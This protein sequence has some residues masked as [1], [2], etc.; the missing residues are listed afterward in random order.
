MLLRKLLL[1]LIFATLFTSCGWDLTAPDDGNG[2]SDPDK[3]TRFTN[4]TSDN[5]PNGLD[6]QSTHAQAAYINGDD[7]LDIVVSVVNEP[8]KILI[9]D[10]DGVF[11]DQ[12]TRIPDEQNLNSQN[13]TIADFNSDDNTDLYFSNTQ[14]QSNELYMNNS[15]G[16]FS[17]LSNRIPITGSFTSAVSFDVDENGTM[18][19]VI[20][21]R[22][23]NVILMNS[24]NAFFNNQSAERLPQ[25]SD[26]TLDLAYGDISGDGNDDL[27]I[28][29][30]GDNF[31]LIN[32][33]NGV[34]NNDSNNRLPYLSD[35][36]ESRS[37]A[38]ADVDDD[39]DLDIY[40]GNSDSLQGS[41]PQDRLL[42]NDGDG[43]FSDE[44]SDRLPEIETNTYD[45]EFSDLNND[46]YPDLTVGNHDGGIQI[47]INDGD[48]NFEDKTEEWIPADFEPEV[49]DLEIADFNG[50]DLLDIYVSVQDDQDQ[51]LLQND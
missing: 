21:S 27:V 23:Q 1:Y 20:G 16:D 22:D 7:S 28:A 30:R 17:N 34:F 4:V 48:G 43:Y 6:D 29:N 49:N 13:V 39:N 11:S 37:V 41:N 46:G 25:L 35:I 24:G 15:T 26:A 2:D 38:L 3:E 31:V 36:E 50:D 14:N 40:F 44:T 42:V 10:G 47:L 32:T 45:A 5:L 19:L 12:S 8:N 9:N 18:D 33:G 51:L